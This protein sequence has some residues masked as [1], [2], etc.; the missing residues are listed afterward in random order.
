MGTYFNPGN[1]SFTKDTNNRIYIDKTGLLEFMNSRIG[2]SENCLAISHARRF[3]KSQAAGMLDAYY[4]R[5]CDSKALFAGRKISESTDFVTYL[6]QYNVIHLDM[7]SIAEHCTRGLIEEILFRLKKDFR[8]AFG[9]KI[10]LDQ[11]IELILGD[12]YKVTGISLIIVIDEWDCVIRNQSDDPESVHKY[13]Q[14]LHSLF[15]SEEAKR[16]LALGY[17]TGILPVKK[18][19]DESALNNFI[20]YTMVESDEL[21]PFFGFTEDEVRSLCLQYG[22]E[23]ESIRS[24]YDGY[25]ISGMSMYNPNS[26]CLAMNKKRLDSFWKNTSAFETINDYIMLNYDGL[27]DAVLTMLSGGKASVDVNSFQNDLS[28]IDSKDDALTALIHLGYLAYDAGTKKAYIPN[29]EV[30]AA[31]EQAIKKGKWKELA[32]ILSQCDEML[33][34]TLAMNVEKVA[35]VLEQSHDMHT[36]ILKY[37]DENAL[38]CAITMAYF[39][40]RAYYDIVREMPAGKGFADITFLPRKE[41]GTKPALIVELKWDQDAETAIRQIKEKNYTGVLADYEEEILLV[42]VNY[43]RRSK[44]HTCL[45]ER[46][47]R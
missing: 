21:T 2:S 1:E 38:A 11:E 10:D 32:E 44:K 5:G 7:S 16:F 28:V 22:M 4:S 20:E 17:I 14:F 43:D 9:D 13:L 39:T 37:N 46:F 3:G 8:E 26:V 45:I 36:S 6:N 40:A 19:K 15:K 47:C 18:I 27:K 23:F 34:A 24:W 30:S 33:E 42:G 29:Y 25:T 31:F 41:A 12:I 35:E